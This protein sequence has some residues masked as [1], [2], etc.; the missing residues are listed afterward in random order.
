[1]QQI[2]P[3]DRQQLGLIQRDD[4]EFWCVLIKKNA[5]QVHSSLVWPY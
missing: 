2:S 4:G 1:M 3:E 5:T